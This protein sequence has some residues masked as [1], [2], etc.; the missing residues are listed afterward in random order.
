MSLKIYKEGN[1]VVILDSAAAKRI[2]IG[3]EDCV[4]KKTGYA[5]AVYAIFDMSK[6]RESEKSL[7]SNVY[8]VDL[9]NEN[10]VAWVEAEFDVFRT[11]QVGTGTS[12]APVSDDIW[13]EA[14][15]EITSA[16]IL[17][18][19]STPIELLPAP[20][21]EKYY[22]WKVNLEYTHV[23]TPYST[24]ANDM[25]VIGGGNSYYGH[26]STFWIIEGVT[27]KANICYPNSD[28]LTSDGVLDYPAS[29][30]MEMN[31]SLV[32]TTLNGNNPTLG[33]GTIRAIIK[34]KVK[35]FGA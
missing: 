24:P 34:Y 10:D 17:A 2:E 8:L 23:T 3:V 15:V 18:M 29:N 31:D 13:V 6:P 22:D 9:I 7:Y 27:N 5:Q 30:G 26:Y 32:L 25:M 33:D 28:T 4:I 14:I 19:G 20:G 11:E 16:Q 1:V 21:A 35:T 12:V